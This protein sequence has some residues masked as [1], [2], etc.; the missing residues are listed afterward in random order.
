MRCLII[1]GGAVERPEMLAEAVRQAD[2]VICVDGGL[3][4]IAALGLVPDLV[5]GD[6]DSVDRAELVK[7]THLGAVVKEYPADKDDTDTALALAE[8]LAWQ[9]D[10]IVLLGATG[11]RF[12]HTLANVHLLRVALEQGVRARIVNDYH[13]I[14]LVAPHLPAVVEGKEEDLFSLL[15]LTEEVTGVNVSGA[16]W[17]LENAVFRIGNPYGVSNRLAGARAEI[18]VGRGLMLLVRVF[19]K[20]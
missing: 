15:P 2:R 19:E 12:D 11:T 7:I 1:S 9:P 17:P 5:V 10:E 13:E 3:K 20:E 6:M 8:A 4:H 14:S 18:T 16:R